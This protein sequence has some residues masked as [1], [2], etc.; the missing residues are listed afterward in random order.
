M[1]KEKIEQ[2]IEK[3][4]KKLPDRKKLKKELGSDEYNLICT[5]WLWRIEEI[6]F[7]FISDLKSL[8][9]TTEEREVEYK[10][11]PVCRNPMWCICASD[12]A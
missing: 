2:L 5:Q 3:R 9:D 7:E 12:N 4:E 10:W 8:Q 11:C 6:I 1:T